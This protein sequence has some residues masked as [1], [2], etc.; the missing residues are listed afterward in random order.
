MTARELLQILQALGP[1]RLDA[2]VLVSGGH[3][4]SY[5]KIHGVGVRDV[6]VNRHGRFSEYFTDED[7]GPGGE[8]VSGIVLS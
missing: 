3:D 2:P 4:H 5:R 6:E 7:M 1:E 8:K